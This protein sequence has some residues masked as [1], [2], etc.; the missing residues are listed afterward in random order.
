MPAATGTRGRTGGSGSESPSKSER[1][2]ERIVD[3]TAKV[4]NARGYSGTRLSDIAD[5]A[6]VQ[7]P[8]I[9]Y[10][11]S[12]REELVEE[13]VS[14]GLQRTMSL[15]REA[16]DAVPTT[17]TPLQRIRAAVAAH[18][19]TLL[20]HSDHAAAAMRTVQQLPHDIR[21]RQLAAHRAYLDVWRGLLDDA[22][23]AGEMDPALDVRAA[24]MIVIGALNWTVEWWDPAEGS[25]DRVI[26]TAQALI[27]SGLA[28][29]E[30]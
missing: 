29:P 23:A 24:L 25:L 4:L 30:A 13:A 2:R 8:A 17:A 3:A 28:A 1:T 22:R 19:N 11:F 7:A 14:V 9:Y 15:L 12:S 26:A 10:Y 27:E 16:L 5:L 20:T 18:L 6:E 21:E